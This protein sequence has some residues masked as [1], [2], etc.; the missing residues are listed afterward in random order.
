MFPKEIAMFDTAKRPLLIFGAGIHLS[1]MEAEAL[2]F[3]RYANIPVVCTWGAV[4]IFH[5]DDPLYFGGSGTHGNRYSNFAVQNADVI[6]TLGTRLDTKTTGT[7]VKDF[8]PKATVYMLDIDHAEINKFAKMGRA[9]TGIRADLR[10]YLP[11]TRFAAQPYADW[12]ARLREW[13]AKYPPGMDIGGAN[14]YRFVETLS[15]LSLPDD[16]IVSDTGNALGYMMQA[17]K[18]S[19]Q[20]FIH[21]WNNTPMGYGLPAAIGA[22]FAT[23]RRV[24]C[25][26][27]DGGLGVN[28]TELAT[29][30]RHQ[31]NVKVILFNNYGHQM[32]RQT[33]RT[34][35]GGTYPST[36]YEGGLATPDY[37]AVARAYDIPVYAHVHDMLHDTDPGFFEFKMPR[38]YEYQLAPQVQFGR[39]LDDAHPL[40]PSEELEAIRNV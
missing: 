21:A 2:A 34:W 14:P 9:I 37:S 30:A 19:G 38:L 11:M 28:I 5:H 12:F 17:F 29:L 4:D 32:C 23:E 8:A 16:V 36:S 35:L 18:F 26:T 25:I 27:G 39:Q 22:S 7:P 6:L 40:L 1:G 20:R 33:Q 10:K 15:A 3:A 24:I 13:K 31:R